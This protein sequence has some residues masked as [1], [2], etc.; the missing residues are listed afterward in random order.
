MSEL[1]SSPF[2]LANPLLNGRSIVFD[3]QSAV[4]R[5]LEQYHLE[6]YHFFSR[7]EDPVAVFANAEISYADYFRL[8]WAEFAFD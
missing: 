4:R 7:H 1:S 6:T 3:Q 2:Q 5:F 8:H